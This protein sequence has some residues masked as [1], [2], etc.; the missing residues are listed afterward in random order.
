MDF[1]VGVHRS[2]MWVGMHPN[3]A[4]RVMQ[5]SVQRSG[6]TGEFEPRLKFADPR[7]LNFSAKEPRRSQ[8]IVTVGLGPPQAQFDSA[9]PEVVAHVVELNSVIAV[10][11]L[12]DRRMHLQ[13]AQLTA[14]DLRLELPKLCELAAVGDRPGND[15]RPR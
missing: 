3:A 10:C 12:L 6:F 5:T 8:E 9:A 14:V 11:A 13:D 2:E 15:G 1:A 7:A 4:H